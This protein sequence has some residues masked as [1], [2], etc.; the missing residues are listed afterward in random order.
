MRLRFYSINKI[1]II[2]IIMILRSICISVTITAAEAQRNAARAAAAV[3][4]ATRRENMRN[5]IVVAQPTAV[6]VTPAVSVLVNGVFID[7]YK[8][9]GGGG[10]DVG[11]N[12]DG[13]GGGVV[14]EFKLRNT[15]VRE[16]TASIDFTGCTG[17]EL[18]GE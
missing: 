12:V 18:G 8:R 17:L 14:Y 2:I 11:G 3:A 1:T 10:G 6:A 7:R 5:N 15:I 4:E 16:A 9:T 13:G